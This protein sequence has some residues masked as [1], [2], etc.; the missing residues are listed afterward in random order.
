MTGQA[1]RSNVDVPIAAVLL[2][3]ALGAVL[4]GR[5]LTAPLVS[6]PVAPRTG[7]ERRIALLV[8]AAVIATTL[9]SCVELLGEPR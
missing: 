3:V 1:T 9:A 7:N 4:W 5:R 6:S 8:W 2:G